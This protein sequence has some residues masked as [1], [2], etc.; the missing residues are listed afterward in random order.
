MATNI[1]YAQL[2]RPVGQARESQRIET[3]TV[4]IEG[5][6]VLVEGRKRTELQ[7]E[8]TPLGG[9]WQ[10][11]RGGSKEPAL[12]E[13]PAWESVV[14]R[15]TPADLQAMEEA[16]QIKRGTGSG[17]PDAHSPSQILRAV[18]N[19]VDQKQGRLLSL[20]KEDQ[21]IAIEYESASKRTVSEKFTVSSLYDYWV[22]M[23]LKRS[24]RP[25]EG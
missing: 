23:Y 11:F 24:G 13:Q 2:L 18:G 5:E 12:A 8:S 14:K 17:T 9:F 16:A 20:S 19:F 7:R 6:D 4:T 1:T 3:F 21:N 25:D 22:R 15:Y 10:I